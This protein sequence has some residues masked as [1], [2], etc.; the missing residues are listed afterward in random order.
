MTTDHESHSS[1]RPYTLIAELTHACPLACAYCSNPTSS[2]AKPSLSTGDWLRVFAE[3]ADLGVLQVHLT[4]G[5]PLLRKDLELLVARARELDLFVVLITS[6]V[7]LDRERLQRLK[8]AGLDALQLS[9]QD[10][11]PE[12]ATRVCGKDFSEAKRRVAEWT[13]GLGIPLTVNVVLHAG[14][15]DRV[16]EFLALGRELGATRLELANTQ[17]LG[18]A[19]HNR[20]ALLPSA[21]QIQKARDLVR[22]ARAEL[23]SRPEIVLVLPDYYA[24]RPRA[25]MSGWA[26]RY[27]VVAPDGRA[28]P[29]HA[30]TCIPSLSFENVKARSLLSIWHDSDAFRAFRGEGWMQEPCRSCAHRA[31]DFGGCRCQAYLL[32]GDARAA[33]PAC[34]LSPHHARV[35][36]LRA[37]A[38][39]AE[40][41]PPLQLRRLSN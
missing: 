4:G 2:F 7:P 22:A 17:Y 27:L 33:D 26:T 6:G 10:V 16:P 39:H 40:A 25:C 37:R 14:N 15:I 20:E 29:C 3:A 13:V 41:R 24:G 9:F 19:F 21:G 12:A 31:S 11:V 1:P 5:E 36:E 32:S 28:L 34:E 23:Q 30:A 38:E 8:A 35:V 18:H